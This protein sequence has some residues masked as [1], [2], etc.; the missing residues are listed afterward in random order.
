MVYSTS[1]FLDW[2][3]PS[4]FEDDAVTMIWGQNFEHIQYSV[5]TQYNED[6]QEAEA[7][8]F[9][10]TEELNRL[11]DY[12]HTA[13]SYVRPASVKLSL[14]SERTKHLE[15]LKSMNKRELLEKLISLSHETQSQR[16]Q[17][18]GQDRF[19]QLLD[20]LAQLFAQE[21]EVSDL[22]R[23]MRQAMFVAT[24]KQLE[25]LIECWAVP[26]LCNK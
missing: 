1:F 6:T 18:A 22:E 9:N 23:L 2:S 14:S 7:Y 20:K 17:V 11:S 8:L 3:T 25:K 21:A 13:Q 5:A 24:P 19:V 26:V 4:L 10:F 15:H 12:C 16:L